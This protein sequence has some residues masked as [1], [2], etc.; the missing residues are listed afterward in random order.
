MGV[1][2]SVWWVQILVAFSLI[3]QGLSYIL[4]WGPSIFSSSK[5][6]LPDFTTSV[7]ER[8][9]EREREILHCC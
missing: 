3:N 7:T 1:D 8:M 9:R 4:L 2:G 5:E 6:L